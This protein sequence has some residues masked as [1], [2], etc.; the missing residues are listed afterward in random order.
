MLVAVGT[1]PTR[2]ARDRV[3]TT[4]KLA[5]EGADFDTLLDH[6]LSGGLRD[7]P[8]LAMLDERADGEV[9]VLLRGP[10]RAVAVGSS[11]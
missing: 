3:A 2:V 8:G 1:R 9:R 4:W 10:V 11:G 7:L 5:D 6:V